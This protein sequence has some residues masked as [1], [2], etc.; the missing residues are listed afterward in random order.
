M[1]GKKKSVVGDQEQIKMKKLI[2]LLIDEMIG[3]VLSIS[4]P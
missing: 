1:C 2:D 4:R 3:S